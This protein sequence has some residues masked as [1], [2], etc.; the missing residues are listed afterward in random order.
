M[1]SSQKPVGYFELIR[2]NSNF[3]NLWLGQVVSL[4]GDWFNLIASATLIAS[5][6]Q[7][8]LAVSS[9]FVVRMLAPF[10]VS[11]LAGVVADR[12]N[13]KYILIITDVLRAF[14][15]L[16]FL[17]IRDADDLWLLYTLTA[18]QFCVSGFSIPTRTAILPNLVKDHELGTANALIASTWSVML[19]IGAAIGGLVS[20]LWGIYP[21][22][23]ID[24]LTFVVSAIFIARIKFQAEAP[25][26]Q[27]KSM[28]AF[29]RQYVEGLEFLGKNRHVLVS[30]CHK[31]M[32]ALLAGSTFEIIEVAISE[33]V[34]T[35]G[36]GGG[37]SLGLM[38]MMTG[39]GSGIGPIVA[40]NI[41][42]DK[43]RALQIA[44]L[45]GY[46][47]ISVG[48]LIVMPL[49]NFGATLFGILFRGLGGGIV[50]T[51]STQLLLQQ[52]PKHISGRIF[53]S[54]FALFTLTGAV[55][56]LLVGRALDS[57]SISTIL[58]GLAIL[59]LIPGSLWLY[60]ISRKSVSN[61]ARL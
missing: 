26:E 24:A 56:A 29:F 31:A 50:W 39:L 10:L 7:S 36:V 6:S 25:G 40:R 37:I 55:G 58:A 3:R 45:I 18:L 44:I 22:F 46:A 14:I 20:G 42:G 52:A 4:L 33:R 15:M 12:F 32:V 30:A 53:A 34:F 17:F 2:S 41:T 13:R 43:T 47:M 8:G 28:A 11:S 27:A 57:Y 38:F 5:L 51:F 59:I 21:A 16:G 54:E 49:F 9:L 35:L 60:W 23:V 61:K 1:S 48:Y 19:S